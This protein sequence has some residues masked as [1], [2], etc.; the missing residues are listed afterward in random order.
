MLKKYDAVIVKP[1]NGSGGK[2]V[3]RVRK[4]GGR[5]EIRYGDHK[6]SVS[7]LHSAYNF[8]KKKK[9]SSVIVQRYIRLARIGKRPLDLRVMVQRK[10]RKSG[11]KIT[12]KLAKVAGKGYIITNV[13]RS[14]GKVMSAASAVR[15]SDIRGTS[16]RV[17]READRISLL[18]ASRLS[19]NY[20]FI[21]N[22]GM[23]IGV[24]RNGK[25]WIIEANFKPA[26]SL[27][28]PFPKVYR[29]IKKYDK[30]WRSR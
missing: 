13:R 16:A 25:V 12:G 15:K 6:R 1:I 19:R 8:V 4:L 18:A 24:D 10:S 23:D 27:F 30:K 20:S 17:L 11:W 5:Y 9:K 21:H 26:L 29:R 2:G 7:R 28:R 3:M 14:G 22:V